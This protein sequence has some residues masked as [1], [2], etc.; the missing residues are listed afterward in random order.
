MKKN[1]KEISQQKQKRQKK[2]KRRI[3][4]KTTLSKFERQ[5]EFIRQALMRG[6]FNKFAKEQTDEQK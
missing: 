1:N 6:V 5:Q 3:N 4:D 2:N